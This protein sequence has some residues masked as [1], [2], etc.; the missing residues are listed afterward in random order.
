MF[1][2]VQLNK[3]NFVR[4]KFIRF[5]YIIVKGKYVFVSQVNCLPHGERT[6]LIPYV[7][8]SIL[9]LIFVISIL[10]LLFVSVSEGIKSYMWFL[11]AASLHILNS[12]LVTA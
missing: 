6:V 9:L 5:R 1:N 11:R 10:L 3:I 2:C 12:Y 8:A 7:L 4:F